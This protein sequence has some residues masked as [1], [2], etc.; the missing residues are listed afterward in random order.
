MVVVMKNSELLKN[1]INDIEEN[2]IIIAST[3]YKEKYNNQINENTYYK[4]FE[5]LYKSNK[6]CKLS[7]GIYYK[8]KI[9]KYGAIPISESEIIECFTKNN[10]GMVIGYDL[11]NNLNITT[12]ITK[13]KKIY[14]SLITENEKN[15]NNI[16]IKK[17]KLNFNNETKK[18]ITML[19][20]ISN[21]TKIED[22]NYNYFITFCENYI[23][24]YNEKNIDYILEHIKYSKSTIASLKNILEYYKIKNTLEK[25]LSSLSKYNTI[26]MEEIYELTQSQKGI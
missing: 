16:S 3:L 23:K 19:E 5:R 18:N 2:Y 11:Y 9:G 12:Q 24:S 25:Y 15:I 10:K 1:T 26:N 6:I 20:T 14:S 8:P 21:L 7:K 4:I 22:L 17:Y 13:T